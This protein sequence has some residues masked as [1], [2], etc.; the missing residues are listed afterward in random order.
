[1]SSIVS[2]FPNAD[3]RSGHNGLRKLAAKNKKNVD[4]LVPGDLLLFINRAQSA[5]KMFA[6]NNTL[7]HYKSPRGLVDMKTIKYLPG[8]L[9][10]GELDYNKA[11][12][13]VLLETLGKRYNP[14]AA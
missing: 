10:G 13:K 3:L 5:F 4:A 6:A 7:I 12:A 11:L 2:V 8:C 9:S 14:D 1:M